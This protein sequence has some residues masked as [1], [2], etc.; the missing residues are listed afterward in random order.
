M[1]GRGRE[2]GG[3]E[4]RVNDGD[5]CEENDEEREKGNQPFRRGEGGRL[6]S[7]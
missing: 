6:G 2:E 7:C 5:V 4:R 3:R 1:G